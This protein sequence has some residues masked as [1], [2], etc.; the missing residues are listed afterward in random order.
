MP[1]RT[2]DDIEQMPCVA[3]GFHDDGVSNQPVGCA[4]EHEPTGLGELRGER[5]RLPGGAPM[6]RGIAARDHLAGADPEAEGEP[7]GALGCEL[8]GETN[9]HCAQFGGS[10]HRAQGVV[11]VHRRQAEDEGERVAGNGLDRAAVPFR[12]GVT[13]AECPTGDMTERLRIERLAEPGG[14]RDPDKD[15]GDGLASFPR[16]MQ[17]D[18]VRIQ[19]RGSLLRGTLVR[20]R[21]EV[22]CGVL[23]QDLLV[24]L[25]QSAARLDA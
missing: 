8:L 25:A 2:V 15:G 18:E 7:D 21:R 22:E 12:S 17:L 20:C 16:Q 14:E 11:L 19:S 13:F 5:Q 3:R 9:E 23:T 6:G 10:P 4:V 24:E 1:R